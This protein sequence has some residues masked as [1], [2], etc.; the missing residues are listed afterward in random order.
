MSGPQA[1][2]DKALPRRTVQY[3]IGGV[4]FLAIFCVCSYSIRLPGPGHF[5]SIVRGVGCYGT[6]IPVVRVVCTDYCRGRSSF[7]SVSSSSL[8][9]DVTCNMYDVGS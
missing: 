3:T 9:R 8:P 1:G 5:L 7:R 6:H 4:R 2:G